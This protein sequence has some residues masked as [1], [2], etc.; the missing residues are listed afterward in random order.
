MVMFRM[1][2]KIIPF[3]NMVMVNMIMVKWSK[4]VMARCSELTEI[5]PDFQ[6][7]STISAIKLFK[8]I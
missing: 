4:M 2:M 5:S 7:I 8:K 6:Q 3:E 1:N